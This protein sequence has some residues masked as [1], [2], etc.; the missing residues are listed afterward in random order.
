MDMAVR[1][2]WASE[3]PRRRRWFGTHRTG[4]RRW[5]WIGPD[6]A[7]I[8][9]ARPLGLH[10]DGEAGRGEAAAAEPVA[11]PFAAPRQPALDRPDR[12]AQMP[13]RLLVGAA[14]EVAE[15]D[16]RAEPLRQ[17]VDLLVE[18]RPVRPSSFVVSAGGRRRQLRRPALVP[19]SRSRP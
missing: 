3:R 12:P 16:R 15:D 7:G 8:K 9:S 18:Q 17:P 13:R 19:P 2:P 6:A 14:L 10:G 1:T 4:P 11:E 5:S